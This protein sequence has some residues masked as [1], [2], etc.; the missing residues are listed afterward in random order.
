MKK[1]ENALVAKN[2]TK[3]TIEKNNGKKELKPYCVEA[4]Q[5]AVQKDKVDALRPTASAWLQA[6]LDEDPE[7]KAFTG[8]VVCVYDGSLYKIRV[9]RPDN[10]DWRKKRIN[11]DPRHAA[12]LECYKQQDALKMQVAQLEEA[13]AEDHPKCVSKGFVISFLSK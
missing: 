8:T 3:L 12:L 13:L 2:G 9:Q 11:N 7:T 10:T 1:N 6:K 4:K 5:L